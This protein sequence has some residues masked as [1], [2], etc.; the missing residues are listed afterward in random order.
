MSEVEKEEKEKEKL[1]VIELMSEP[2]ILCVRQGFRTNVIS[3]TRKGVGR[4]L[5]EM[6]KYSTRNIEQHV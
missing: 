5:W 3:Q 2:D 6:D 4:V 1:K